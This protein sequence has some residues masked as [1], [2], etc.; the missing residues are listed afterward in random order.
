M[1]CT[2]M[3]D[4]SDPQEK[5]CLCALVIAINVTAAICQFVNFLNLEKGLFH[6]R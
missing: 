3:N 2:E 6:R 1:L 4:V 5:I